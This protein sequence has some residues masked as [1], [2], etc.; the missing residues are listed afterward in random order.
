MNSI[1]IPIMSENCFRAVKAWFSET[2]AAKTIEKLELIAVEKTFPDVVNF[3]CDGKPRYFLVSAEIVRNVANSI[4]QHI[5]ITPAEGV[6]LDCIKSQLDGRVQM[7]LDTENKAFAEMY[8]IMPGFIRYFEAPCPR[9]GGLKRFVVEI[10][11][12]AS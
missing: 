9:G 6:F 5:P 11:A 7:H 8:T 10:R 12:S 1:P 2:D 4:F 3:V